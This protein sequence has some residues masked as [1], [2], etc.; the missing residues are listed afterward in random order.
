MDKQREL[1][2]WR[3]CEN[4]GRFDGVTA[5]KLNCNRSTLKRVECQKEGFSMWEP[6]GEIAIV[7]AEWLGEQVSHMVFNQCKA[8]IF[9]LLESQ[10]G[11]EEP[12]SDA[13]YP[14]ESQ[15]LRA[16]KRMAQ[17]IISGIAKDA[18]EFIVDM[19]ADW[20]EKLI[21]SDEAILTEDEEAEA[22]K[23]YEET[24]EALK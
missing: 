5:N 16:T 4:C 7:D 19:L 13:M 17:D 2:A 22:I 6:D 9:N 24:K 8:K 23:E 18:K 1:P 15:R 11:M 21:I 14:K 20:E 12:Y 10:L 3:K